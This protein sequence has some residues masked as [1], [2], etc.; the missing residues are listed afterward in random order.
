M[1]CALPYRWLS[2][3]FDTQGNVRRK[4]KVRV[5]A[6]V[7]RLG[8]FSGSSS[9]FIAANTQCISATTTQIRQ[10]RQR[11]TQHTNRTRTAARDARPAFPAKMD[12]AILPSQSH[13]TQLVQLFSSSWIF[14]FSSRKFMSSSS[15]NFEKRRQVVVETCRYLEPDAFSTFAKPMKPHVRG[16]EWN[17]CHLYLLIVTIRIEISKKL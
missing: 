15:W 2:G 5:G 14:F 6:K 9:T 17:E 8:E 12:A 10:P 4:K 7:H 16:G 11:W 1:L 13:H 3:C